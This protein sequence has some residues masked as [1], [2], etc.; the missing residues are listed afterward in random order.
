MIRMFSTG[1]CCGVFVFWA[2]A[3]TTHAAHYP[4]YLAF[5]AKRNASG[6]WIV[7]MDMDHS[8][9]VGWQVSEAFE[10]AVDV[11]VR[12]CRNGE[13]FDITIH[14]KGPGDPAPR[15]EYP[16]FRIPARHDSA[17]GGSGNET[18]SWQDAARLC[19]QR[20]SHLAVVNTM[21][22]LAALTGS[23]D[24]RS[25]AYIGIR[26]HKGALIDQ[27]GSPV[28]VDS[29]LM[30]QPPSPDFDVCYVADRS[31]M[32]YPEPCESKVSYVCER[33]FA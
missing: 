33:R 29:T 22:D 31:F 6:Y 10:A 30:V 15:D 20:R 23:L 9:G 25:R 2:L 16:M 14:F 4:M 13:L 17:L 1:I 8:Y 7:K 18:A 24:H 28:D 26:N 19:R 27:Y 11:A 21:E 3:V 5:T 12:T 32:M